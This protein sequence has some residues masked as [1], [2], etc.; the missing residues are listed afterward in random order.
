MSDISLSYQIQLSSE[1]TEILEIR[2]LGNWTMGEDLPLFDTVV[3]SMDEYTGY[4]RIRVNGASIQDWDSRLIVFLI[5]L[6]DFSGTRK[7]AFELQEMP[8]GVHDFLNL[9]SA[10][11]E[12]IGARKE[13]RHATFLE[14]I[15]NDSIELAVETRNLLAFIGEAVLSLARFL[16]GR[17]RFRSLDFWWITQEC[18]PHALPIVT[19]IS[20]LIGLILAFVGVM[21]LKLFGA[22]IYIADLVALG[23][24]REMGAMMTAIIMAGRTGAAFAA[25]LGAMQVNEEIDAFKTMGILP[26]DF[27]VLP[28]MLALILMM[29]M[30]CLYSDLMGIVGGFFVGVG[31]MDLSFIEYYEQTKNAVGLADFAVGL[32]KSSVFGVLVALTGCM[33][34][35]NC[36]RS[37]TAVGRAATAAVVTGIVAI[38]IADSVLTVIYDR[39]GV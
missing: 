4:E 28:R 29:P 19:L 11:P 23:M 37:S 25:Q 38:V 33:Q 10:V 9:A 18:G 20:F 8:E 26:F 12:R 3:D 16:G 7:I 34:G 32:I 24:A 31:L 14:K 30:L 35:I 6:N 13:G 22:Q 27:L 15:G 17:A 2:L 39:L 1:N 5:K 36:G 21:Q